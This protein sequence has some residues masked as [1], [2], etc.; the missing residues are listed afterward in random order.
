MSAPRPSGTPATPHSPELSPRTQVVAAGRPPRA[1]GASLNPPVT[2]TSTY[3]ADGPVNYA[4][5]DNP[6]WTPF[7]EAV[8]GLEGGQ[9]LLYSSGMAA[10]VAVL[11]LVPRG[12]VVVAPAAAYNGV[13]VSLTEAAQEGLLEVRWVDITDTA[14]VRAA[15]P[16]ADLIWLESPTNPLLDVADLAGLT[17]A[18]HEAGALVAVDNTFATP[19]LQRPLDEGADIVVH[20]ATKYLAGHSDVILG[21]TVTNDDEPGRELR[22]RLA[23]HRTLGGAIA[24]PMEAWLALRGLRTLSLRLERACENAVELARRLADHPRVSRVRYPGWGAVVSVEVAGRT[25]GAD[26]AEALA[27]GTRIWSNSTSLGGVESQLE[28]RR[29]QPGEPEAVP[30]NLVRMSVGVEDVDDLWRDLEQSLAALG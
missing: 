22:T 13:V 18:A 7:E 8:G 14:G 20:S 21:L 25:D 16:G 2:F 27:A 24:G 15:L 10:V 3:I 5:V 19:L 30:V 28:R 29:R 1:P 23:R 4:R 9:A 26:E 6:T 17:A 11:A 12:G